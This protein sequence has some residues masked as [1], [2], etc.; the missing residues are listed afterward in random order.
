MKEIDQKT[1]FPLIPSILIQSQ[2]HS[3]GLRKKMCVSVCVAGKWIE[4]EMGII[5]GAGVGVMVINSL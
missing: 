3:G 5:E 2:I 4:E 1:P